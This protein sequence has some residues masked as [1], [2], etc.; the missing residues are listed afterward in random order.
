MVLPQARSS[1]TRGTLL[2]FDH[3]LHTAS[4]KRPDSGKQQA[5]RPNSIFID[6][7]WRS[8]DEHVPMRRQVAASLG[9]SIDDSEIPIQPERVHDAAERRSRTSGSGKPKVTAVAYRFVCCN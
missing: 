4:M 6:R 8:R 2:T 3:E 5:R 1:K 9:A 7:N